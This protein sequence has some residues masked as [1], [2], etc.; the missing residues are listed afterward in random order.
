MLCTLARCQISDTVIG[1]AASGDSQAQ[2][3]VQAALKNGG[4][5]IP[6]A[7]RKKALAAQPTTSAD[8]LAAAGGK[9][10]VSEPGNS[11]PSN[12]NGVP[13]RK[14]I[15]KCQTQSFNSNSTPCDEFAQLKACVVR[16]CGTAS[17]TL[18]LTTA[19]NSNGLDVKIVNGCGSGAANSNTNQKRNVAKFVRLLLGPKAGG[20]GN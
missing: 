11:S 5:S 2:A 3:Q 20:N 14:C 17:Q 18:W 1:A 15:R 10:T 12:G 7:I 9:N 19:G 16:T 6:A 8:Q 4:D 13:G